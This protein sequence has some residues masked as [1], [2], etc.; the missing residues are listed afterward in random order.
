LTS[1]GTLNKINVS[2]NEPNYQLA[3][4]AG[5]SNFTRGLL[6]DSVA[7][8]HVQSLDI[9]DSAENISN[10]F[11][12]LQN[13]SVTAVHL[14]SSPAVLDITGSQYASSDSLAKVKTPFSMNVREAD[15]AAANTLQADQRV[16]TFDVSATAAQI[17]ASLPDLL[18]LS[19]LAH[20]NITPGLGSTATGTMTLTA[21]QYLGAQDSMDRVRGNYA[22]NLTGVS[23]AAL[24]GIAG[25]ANVAGIQ[26]SDTTTAVAGAWAAL[27]AMG[28]QLTG[29]ELTSQSPVAITLSQWNQ[30][31]SAL[32][33]LPSGHPL[34]LLD[35]LPDQATSAAGYANVATVAVK[36]TAKQVAAVFDDLVNLGAQL[37]DIEFTDTAPLIL[38]QSQV[39]A[40]TATLAKINGSVDL[41]IQS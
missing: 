39:D 29:I 35:V 22:F 1:V 34:A 24:D 41:Q 33:K 38:T 36:G 2:N 37:D 11:D 40:G 28:D 15:P 32:T 18:A 25:Q 16:N 12:L 19:H 13:S 7:S 31:A 20:V 14:T 27:V 23:T 6:D 21:E 5:D 26:V 30:S 8:A 17:G 4:T 10:N 3:L 9:S